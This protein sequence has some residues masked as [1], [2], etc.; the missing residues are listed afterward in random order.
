MG[1]KE[2]WPIGSK[3]KSL[4]G[5]GNL[6]EGR[7][8]ARSQR[9]SNA[10]QRAW[11]LSARQWGVTGGCKQLRD[12]TRKIEQHEHR[13]QGGGRKVKSEGRNP[14]RMMA[15]ILVQAGD[16]GGWAGGGRH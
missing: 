6:E 13:Q 8:R 7:Q 4:A 10:H 16:D 14:G 11:D 3:G 9:A 12:V 1:Y 2:T 5:R 15:T